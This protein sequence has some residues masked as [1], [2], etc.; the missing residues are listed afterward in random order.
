VFLLNHGVDMPN[1]LDDIREEIITH[2][3]KC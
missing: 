1:F 3:K 2:L